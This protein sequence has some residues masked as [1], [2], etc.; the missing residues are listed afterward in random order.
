MSGWRDAG[1]LGKSCFGLID[2]S[3]RQRCFSRFGN[4]SQILSKREEIVSPLTR[5][6]VSLNSLKIGIRKQL[7]D[8]NFCLSSFF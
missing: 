4:K 6:S 3:G 5:K 2:L 8:Y 7:P 1:S